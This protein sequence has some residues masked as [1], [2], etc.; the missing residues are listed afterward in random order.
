MY[1][2]EKY[3]RTAAAALKAFIAKLDCKVGF[4]NDQ[5]E[6]E[7]DKDDTCIGWTMHFIDNEWN[8]QTLL[9]DVGYGS[10]DDAGAVYDTFN[11]L[12]I[13]RTLA[14]KILG[15]TMTEDIADDDFLDMLQ[16]NPGKKTQKGVIITCFADVVNSACQTIAKVLEDFCNKL[17]KLVHDILLNRD[18]LSNEDNECLK[19]TLEEWSPFWLF[20]YKWT[21]AVDMIEVALTHRLPS[22][23]IWL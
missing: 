3:Y 13:D 8:L 19:T 17:G 22:G 7:T 2:V 11:L 20:E 12:I 23:Q 9:L 4:T 16:E 6:N 10:R 14:S 15:I 1:D 5:W 18:K 21:I